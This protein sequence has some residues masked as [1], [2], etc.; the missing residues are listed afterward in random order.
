MH[1]PK[2]PLDLSRVETL[3]DGG[4]KPSLLTAEHMGA[5]VW[6]AVIAFVVCAAI[7]LIAVRSTREKPGD[8]RDKYEMREDFWSSLGWSCAIVPL[9]AL[10]AFAGSA[11]FSYGAEISDTEVTTVPSQVA[12][13]IDGRYDIEVTDGQ[14]GSLTE[15]TGEFG[16]CSSSQPCRRSVVGTD[17]STI[18][19]LIVDNTMILV[20]AEDGLKEI[21]VAGEE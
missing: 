2:S 8:R 14:A 7:A 10:V 12:D 3:Y 19:S 6:P 11:A 15:T 20:E 21:P 17:G 18:N 16:E 9:F 1:D 13:W 4:P 5:A